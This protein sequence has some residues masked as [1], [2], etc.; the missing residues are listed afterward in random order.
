MMWNCNSMC[1]VTM[2]TVVARQSKLFSV[3][4]QW[5]QDSSLI[6]KKSS[7]CLM[8]QSHSDSV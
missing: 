6:S 2:T 4:E 3:I 1:T 7:V 5:K 8:I